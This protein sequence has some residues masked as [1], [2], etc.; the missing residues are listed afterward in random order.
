MAKR[1]QRKPRSNAAAYKKMAMEKTLIDNALHAEYVRM[2]NQGLSNGYGTAV[3]VMF[4]LLHTEHGFGK[5]RLA[6]FMRKI[7][8]F[9][10]EMLGPGPDGQQKPKENEFSGI[11]LQDIADQ[12]AEECGVYIDTKTW[13]MEVDGIE[14][15]RTEEKG[16]SNG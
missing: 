10:L 4:W 3:L 6:V 15:V 5:K 12:L 16:D 2:F 14:V 1:K 7:N 11:S 8:D 13:L 9:C